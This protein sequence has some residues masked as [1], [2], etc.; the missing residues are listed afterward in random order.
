M[1]FTAGQKLR[2]S[3]LNAEFALT[4]YGFATGDITKV[5]STAMSNITGLSFSL[6]ANSRYL[7]DGFVS[8]YSIDGVDLRLAFTGPAGMTVS[9]GCTGLV[10]AATLQAGDTDFASFET[11]GDAAFQVVNTETDTALIVRPGGYFATGAT[12]GTLQMRFA[13]NVSNA[14]SLVIKR[15]SWL[16]LYKAA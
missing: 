2:A 3:E 15:G 5:S 1:P 10:T 11:Y 16:R 4:Q 14:A 13:Q 9:W 7:L 12:T 6:A 8:Y